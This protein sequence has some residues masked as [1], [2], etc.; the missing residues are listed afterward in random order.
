MSDIRDE[1]LWW[2][3]NQMRRMAR[4]LQLI[5]G[6]LGHHADAMNHIYIPGLDNCADECEKVLSEDFEK[7]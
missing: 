7:W 4:V 2:A 1:K 3:I 5:E 6:D